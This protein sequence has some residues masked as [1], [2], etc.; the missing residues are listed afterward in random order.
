MFTVLGAACKKLYDVCCGLHL[1]N[2]PPLLVGGFRGRAKLIWVNRQIGKKPRVAFVCM[3]FWKADW[4]SV[5]HLFFN[6]ISFCMLCLGRS[7]NFSCSMWYKIHRFIS[8]FLILKNDICILVL[9]QYW[10]LTK[11]SLFLCISPP[12]V[13]FTAFNSIIYLSRL[14]YY[15]ATGIHFACLL[16]DL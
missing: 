14:M 6:L 9:F 8:G 7:S 4:Y 12:T 2:L 11:S 16:P 13:L 3:R 15:L 5:Y 10:G 1:V